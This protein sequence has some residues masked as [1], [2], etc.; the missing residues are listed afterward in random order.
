MNYGFCFVKIEEKTIE[1]IKI[2]AAHTIRSHIEADHILSI[3]FMY[4]NYLHP[5]SYKMKKKTEFAYFA[6]QH[7]LLFTYRRA[8]LFYSGAF[9]SHELSKQTIQNGNESEN[10]LNGN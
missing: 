3:A 8:L 9:N 4:T 5:Y 1:C 2:D 10:E 6:V 7:V